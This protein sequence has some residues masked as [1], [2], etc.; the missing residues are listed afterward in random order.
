MAKTENP[1]TRGPKLEPHQV[2]LRPLVTEKVVHLSGLFNQY[3]FEVNPLA[4]KTMIRQAV[5]FLYDVR[6]DKV[7]TQT[8][9]GKARRYR[10]K[11]GRTKGWKKA[12]VRLKPDYRIEL[13]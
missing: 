2:I 9:R 5:E 11:F 1:V 3:V 13:Y 12:I 6:V 4:T 7:A 10:F 8:R